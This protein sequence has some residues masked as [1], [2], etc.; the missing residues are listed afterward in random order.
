MLQPRTDKGPEQIRVQDAA[1]ANPRQVKEERNE[2]DTNRHKAEIDNPGRKALLVKD[3][4]RNKEPRV[5]LDNHTGSHAPAVFRSKVGNQNV[6]HGSCVMLKNRRRTLNAMRNNHNPQEIHHKVEQRRREEAMK[7][8]S[9]PGIGDT[10]VLGHGENHVPVPV[11]DV[12]GHDGNEHNEIKEIVRVAGPI[13][14]VLGNAG[15]DDAFFIFI[16]VYPIVILQKPSTAGCGRS[17]SRSPAATTQ[18]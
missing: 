17:R 10:Y 7:K 9:G 12:Q 4:P 6:Q 13:V 18:S 11:H 14:V 1:N 3:S 5:D 2:L 16:V 15:Q 8:V